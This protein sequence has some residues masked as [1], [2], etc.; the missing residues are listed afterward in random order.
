MPQVLLEVR[1]KLTRA[2]HKKAGAGQRDVF[3]VHSDMFEQKFFGIFYVWGN[4]PP[5]PTPATAPA[6]VHG[7]VPAIPTTTGASGSVQSSARTLSRSVSPSVRSVAASAAGGP[8]FA[9]ARSVSPA[10]SQSTEPSAPPLSQPPPPKN[11]AQSIS[12]PLA[13]VAMLPLSSTVHQLLDP[14][15]SHSVP[16]PARVSA[17]ERALRDSDQAVTWRDRQL[18]AKDDQMATLQAQLDT[19]LDHQRVQMAMLDALVAA[20]TTSP[21]GDVPWP[22][23]QQ[24]LSQQLRAARQHV[25]ELTHEL[26]LARSEVQEQHEAVRWAQHV[27]QKLETSAP[28][29]ATT[30]EI[31]QSRERAAVEAQNTKVLQILQHKDHCLEVCS[32]A[33][34]N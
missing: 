14:T 5:A 22:V 7:V 34:P 20:D 30:V 6:L 16:L 9:P 27:Q 29:V 23:Q 19:A 11:P 18:Q 3:H 25:E 28:D 4:T 26:T 10:R 31:L 8:Q 13:G 21:Q 1:L 2:P 12:Q 15:T 17:L 24:S 33:K 32:K